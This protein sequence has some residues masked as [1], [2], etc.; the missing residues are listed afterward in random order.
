MGVISPKS[1]VNWVLIGYPIRPK[2]DSSIISINQS[3]LKYP[4]TTKETNET[5]RIIKIP[6]KP[7]K[8]P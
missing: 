2:Y 1:N 5:S 8:W 4:K 6:L 7:I 3:T